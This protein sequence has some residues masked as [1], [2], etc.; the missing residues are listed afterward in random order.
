[1]LRDAGVV[2]VAEGL[3][4]DVARDDGIRAVVELFV[5]VDLEVNLVSI[6]TAI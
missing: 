4:L 6:L 3:E 1:M 5:E 2:A